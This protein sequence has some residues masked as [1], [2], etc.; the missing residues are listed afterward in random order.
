M[1]PFG[2]N[3]EEGGRDAH[4]VPSTD[5]GE[6]SALVRRQGVGD[7]RGG[8]STGGSGN[9]VGNDLHR[10]TAGNCGTVGGSKFT[11]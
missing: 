3:G 7:T 5:H 10:D 4:W 1:G 11:I 2:G 9:P 6:V 8:R